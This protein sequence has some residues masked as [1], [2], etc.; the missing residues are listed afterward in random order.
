VIGLH[1]SKPILNGKHPKLKKHLIHRIY[2]LSYLIQNTYISLEL[3]KI[4]KHSLF[5]NIV[6]TISYTQRDEYFVEMMGCENAN[7]SI[8]KTLARQFTIQDGGLSSG[9]CGWQT[10]GWLLLPSVSREG[11]LHVTGLGKYPSSKF[12]VWVL[13]NSYCFCMALKLNVRTLGLSILT[14][15]M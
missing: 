6:L 9:M 7:H 2:Q 3:G 4:I 10:C 11:G 15:S 5:Y 13:L 1:S 14:N 8:Q 12:K